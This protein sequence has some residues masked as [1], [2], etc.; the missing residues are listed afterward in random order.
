MNFQ[1]YDWDGAF[2]KDDYNG[3]FN[4][5]L[6]E[7]NIHD[8]DDQS[9]NRALK[10]Q[11]YPL[12]K[13]EEGDCEGEV[14]CCFQLLKKRAPEMTMPDP[15]SIKPAL[16]DAFVEIVAIGCRDLSASCAAAK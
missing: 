16:M 5:Q 2:D 14:L 1:L 13:E 3:C 15:P 9:S 6:S 11:W 8:F 12:M 4:A 7:D 10:P